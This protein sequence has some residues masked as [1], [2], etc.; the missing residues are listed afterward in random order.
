MAFQT[1][2]EFESRGRL[3]Y[4]AEIIRISFTVFC[5]RC[6]VVLLLFSSNAL[7]VHANNHIAPNFHAVIQHLQRNVGSRAAIEHLRGAGLFPMCGVRTFFEDKTARN[8][9]KLNIIA[10]VF[11]LR[12]DLPEVA[13]LRSASWNPSELFRSLF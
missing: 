6:V 1:G 5:D 11:D 2:S 8:K 3:N 9:A 12:T 7:I 10:T 13:K 4:E